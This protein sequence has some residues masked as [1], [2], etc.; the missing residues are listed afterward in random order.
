M[1]QASDELRAEMVRRFGS[2]DTVGPEGYLRNA[3]YS[4]NKNWSWVPKPGVVDLKGMT[5]DEFDCLL[6]LVHEWDYGSLTEPDG[7]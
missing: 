4:L 3:G 7:A 2:V 5:S 1:P 6:F